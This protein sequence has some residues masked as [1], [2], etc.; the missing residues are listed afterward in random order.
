MKKVLRKIILTDKESDKTPADDV[1]TKRINNIKAIWHNEHQDDVGLEKLLRLFLAA[2]QFAFPG[3]YIK[4]VFSKKGMD[5]QELAIDI[6]ILLKI[7]F[8][9]YIIYNQTQP[10]YIITFL[11]V[12]LLMETILYISTLVFA[13]D[14]FD[15]PR[16][17]R[18]SMLLMFLDYAQIVFSYAY[19]Y[20]LG[21]HL[22]KPLEHWFDSIYF[23]V[24]TSGTVG[25]GDY[26]PVTSFGKF[27]ASSQIIIFFIIVMFLLNFFS[28]RMEQKGYFGNKP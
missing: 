17:Y 18:R 20:T 7:L 4:Q 11:M 21:N 22:N 8:P 5:Y 6:Y 23:S 9:F 24:V 16:S 2:S 25:Y 1:I 10:T 14:L 19:L 28:H 12:W 27:L 15:R 26:H 3:I 13:S